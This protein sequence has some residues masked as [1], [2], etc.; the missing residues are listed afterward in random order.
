[1]GRRYGGFL[2]DH[3]ESYPEV[4]PLFRR[5]PEEYAESRKPGGRIRWGNRLNL[6]D[7]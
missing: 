3:G 4:D 7:A 6:G 2:R 5:G 1:M